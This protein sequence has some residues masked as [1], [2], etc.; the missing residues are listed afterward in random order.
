MK[1][2]IVALVLTALGL[3]VPAA[4]QQGP[5]LPPGGRANRPRPGL[6]PAE[7][8]EMLDA[9]ALMQ[10]EKQLNLRDAQFGEFV[11]RLKQMQQIRRRNLQGRSQ[12]MRELMRLTNPQR[13]EGDEAT[14][15]E[16]LK[17][18]REHEERAAAELRKA[19][20][21]LDEVLDTR[22]RARF[23]LF[24]E[25]LERRKL[26]LLMRAQAGVAGRPRTLP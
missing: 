13:G 21:A 8:A 7:V 15:K 2:I 10:A 11:T 19:Y 22:Q 25:Q 3:V 5:D 6:A 20:D 1:R 26:D 9:Y 14:L 12:I 4:A 16:K 18:L 24:E 17:S 23:R